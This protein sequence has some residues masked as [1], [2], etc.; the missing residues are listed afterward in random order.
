MD[1]LPPS[2][3]EWGLLR[4][5]AILYSRSYPGLQTVH[6]TVEVAIGGVYWG[7]Y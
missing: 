5:G 4:A 1:I 7:E 3:K 2:H 6:L